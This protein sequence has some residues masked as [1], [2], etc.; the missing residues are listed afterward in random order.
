MFARGSPQPS[1]T[2]SFSAA[3]LYLLQVASEVAGV[4]RW[5]R[6]EAP[7]RGGG[8]GGSERASVGSPM[9]EVEVGGEGHGPALDDATP[10]G[11]EPRSLRR[12]ELQGFPMV[13]GEAPIRELNA[14]HN[15]LNSLPRSIG[16]SRGVVLPSIASS[17]ATVPPPTVSCTFLLEPQGTGLGFLP[18]E[19]SPLLP[20]KA[21]DVFLQIF[22]WNE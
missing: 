11:K 4:L 14:F 9:V 12:S 18:L 1:I 19:T 3:L 20:C 7:V 13:S 8:G 17:W 5:N 22:L 16:H 6:G 10:A 2:G 15:F 21:Q